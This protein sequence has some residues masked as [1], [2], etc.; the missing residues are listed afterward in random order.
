MDRAREKE[1]SYVLS[2][3]EPD[4]PEKDKPVQPGWPSRPPN[5]ISGTAGS[6]AS[7]LADRPREPFFARVAVNRLW[8]W[9]FGEGLQK[10]RAISESWAERRLIQRCSIGW[11][12]EFVGPQVQH[13]KKCIA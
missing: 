5:P 9:H 6:K 1:P 3:G 2:S 7:R 11:P 13:E 12:A 4:R 10:R 8:Q